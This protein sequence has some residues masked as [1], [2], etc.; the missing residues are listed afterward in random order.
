M[1]RVAVIGGG[2]IGLSVAHALVRRGAE[3][4]LLERGSCG[5]SASEG[6]TGWVTP[7]LSAPIPGPGVVRQA[8]RWMADRGSPLLVRPRADPSFL[9]WCVAFWRAS[10]ARRHAR[11]LEATLRLAETTLDA[12]DALVETG[13]EFEMH[14]D[15]LLYLVRDAGAVDDWVRM[16]DELRELGFD[17]DTTV[18]DRDEVHALEPAI[19]GGVAGGLLGRRERHVRPETLTQGLCTWLRAHGADIREDTEVRGVVR[20]AGDWI[21]DTADEPVRVDK[22]VVAAGVESRDVL[23]GLG[24]RVPLEAAKGYSITASNGSAAPRRPLYLTEIKVGASPFDGAVR[25]AG[26]LELGVKDLNIDR[27]RVQA[28]LDGASEYL[29]DWRPDHGRVD[30]AGLRPLLPDAVP[31]VDAVPGSDGVFVA[32]G[33]G[34]L[35]VT[36]APATGEALAPL[37]LEG[38]RGPALAGLGFDRFKG[39]RR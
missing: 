35:G 21:V 7:G 14:A 38:E 34:M 24:V 19:N 29:A 27:R 10:S 18:L 2:V 39:G 32:T 36:L 11:G 28:I 8:I 6:N 33:H 9:G 31:L 37:V 4:V 30:W 3:V 5:G 17:G 20:I 15:G 26:T 23:A 1:T 13:V 12:F 25:L 22:V 16:Y